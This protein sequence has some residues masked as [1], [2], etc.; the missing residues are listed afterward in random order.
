MYNW[1]IQKAMKVKI[2]NV[3]K[4]K[5]HVLG[6]PEELKDFESGGEGK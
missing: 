1:M 3:D 6:T 2:C 4:E 5:I